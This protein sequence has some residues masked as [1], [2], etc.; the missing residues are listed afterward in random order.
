MEVNKDEA[1]RSAQ[2]AAK[3]AQEGD[4]EKAKRFLAKSIRLY[5][6][7]YATSLLKEL[8]S[9]TFKCKAPCT[10]SSS[11]A[12]S[13]TTS[14]RPR[15]TAP[16]APRPRPQPEVP[17][18]GKDYTQ[19]QLDL[20]K[21]IQTAPTLYDVLGIKRGSDTRED[22]V[23][24]GYKK[25]ALRMHPDKNKAPGADE[26]F[27]RVA[28]AFSI[29]SDDDKRRQYDMDGEERPQVREDRGHFHR[30]E[31]IDPEEI[32]NI[33][34]GQGFGAGLRQRGGPQRRGFHSMN[35]H[36]GPHAHA[37]GHSEVRQQPPPLIAFILQFLPIILILLTF[38]MNQSWAPASTQG[39]QPY[40]RRYPS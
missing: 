11:A 37:E 5:S 34:F 29:L 4:V 6:T 9:G 32:F 7:P 31:G 18:L 8:E 21:R 3:F 14:T 23:K 15:P 26:A 28:H 24:K 40:Y 25:V 13:S 1:V 20:V 16:S 2:L 36:A 10:Q 33:F 27:K 39:S 19:E 17:V 22:D 35:P 12:S 38:F 30:G